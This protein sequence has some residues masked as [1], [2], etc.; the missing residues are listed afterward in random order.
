MVVKPPDNDET[1]R[2]VSDLRDRISKLDA[3]RDSGKCLDL[4]DTAEH[5]IDMA[6]SLGYQPLLADALHSAALLVN[7]CGEDPERASYRWK[8]AY[9]AASLG[10][11]DEAVAQAATQIPGLLAGRMNQVSLAREWLHVARAA[12]ERIGDNPRLRVW[13]AVSEGLVLQSERNYGPALESFER[14]RELSDRTGGAGHLD[15]ITCNVDIVVCLYEAGRLEKTLDRARRELPVVI[16]SLGEHHPVVGAFLYYEGESLNGLGRYSEAE[17][18]FKQALAI[19]RDAGSDTRFLSYGLT[20]LGKA[21]LGE[22]RAGDAIGSLEDAESLETR[23]DMEPHEIAETHFT[24]ARALSSQPKARSLSIRLARQARVETGN[25][26]PKQAS[27]IDR[28][29]AGALAT[30]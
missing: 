30:R 15:S 12:V 9:L 17:T 6:R 24:L 8:E 27:E 4:E 25:N 11:H 19:W 10:H 18:A 28:W 3:L 23:K 16:K 29:L 1:R 26:D 21:L 5:I 22:G 2:R 20:G 14:A 7:V 13:L